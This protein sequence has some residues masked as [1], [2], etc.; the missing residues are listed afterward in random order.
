M[1]TVSTGVVH[2]KD[3]QNSARISDAPPEIR[4]IT[5]MG[6]RK[7][8]RVLDKSWCTELKGEK[9]IFHK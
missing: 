7:A 4:V 9:D 3:G 8:V 6:G 1:V 5:F 2:E